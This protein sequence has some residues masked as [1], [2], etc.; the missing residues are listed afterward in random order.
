MHEL[1]IANQIV[2]T[3]TE[4]LAD[5]P[6]RIVRVRLKVGALSGVVADALQFSWDVAT[7]SSRLE[8]SEL[9]IEEIGVV[10]H[11]PQCHKNH[12]PPAAH[13]LRCP[14]CGTWTPEIVAGN[15]LQIQSVEFAPSEETE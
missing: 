6:G 1:S 7:E 13:Q 12:T 15:E 3:V 14:V 8:H 11:C 5:R 10:V 9:V 2:E 4:S